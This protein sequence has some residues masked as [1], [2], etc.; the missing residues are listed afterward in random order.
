MSAVSDALPEVARIVLCR[1]SFGCLNVP[2]L[3]FF[4]FLLP[5]AKHFDLINLINFLVVGLQRERA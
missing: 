5:P 3:V 1:W 2:S 4:P